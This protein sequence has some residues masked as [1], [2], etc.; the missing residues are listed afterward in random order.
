MKKTLLFILLISSNFYAKSQTIELSKIS[1]KA[2]NFVTADGKNSSA[3]GRV[4]G[5]LKQ[6]AARVLKCLPN[7]KGGRTDVLRSQTL[8]EFF[9]NL[10]IFLGSISDYQGRALDEVRELNG[11]TSNE[12]EFGRDYRN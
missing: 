9:E 1:V 7:S 12:L 8:A 6:M 2:N 11:K 10:D 3:E 4:L 5:K